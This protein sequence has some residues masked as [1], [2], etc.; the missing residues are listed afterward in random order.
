MS[1]DRV[2][3]KLRT[4][5]GICFGDNVLSTYNS[6]KYTINSSITN[7]KHDGQGVVFNE[8][9]IDEALTWLVKRKLKLD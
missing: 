9:E 1:K 7:N 3:G 6:G 5:I 8:S 4:V 2:N